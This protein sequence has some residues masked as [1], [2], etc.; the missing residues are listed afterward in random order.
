MSKQNFLVAKGFIE[1]KE[2]NKARDILVHMDNPRAIQWLTRLNEIDPLPEYVSFDDDDIDG[3]RN[4]QKLFEEVQSMFHKGLYQEAID[5]LRVVHR[6]GAF[7]QSSMLLHQAIL[8]REDSSEDFTNSVDASFVPTL[9]QRS[10][11]MFRLIFFVI[12]S[13][14]LLAIVFL[15]LDS[16]SVSS[17]TCSSCSAIDT[18]SEAR[19]C[20][21]DGNT[22]LDHDG[23]GV[24]CEAICSGR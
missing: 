12:V 19:A 14:L 1:A 8:L 2:Y 21:I 24:P 3:I 9:L 16:S 17:G 20:L 13:F 15:A 23:D 18:C 4:F 22:N 5:M 6:N 10:L 7:P 11:Y